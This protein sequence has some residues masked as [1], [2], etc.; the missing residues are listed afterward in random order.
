MRE[1][2]YH[3]SAHVG[4]MR[5]AFAT[6]FVLVLVIAPPVVA[7]TDSSPGECTYVDP[8]TGTVVV[9]PSGCVEEGDGSGGA[10]AAP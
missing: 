9:D 7:A 4:R 6:L 1:L 5:A 3:A 8:Y 10:G 2:G